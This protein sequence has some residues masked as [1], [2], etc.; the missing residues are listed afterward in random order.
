MTDNTLLCL[1][2]DGS[3]PDAKLFPLTVFVFITARVFELYK[4]KM[5]FFQHFQNRTGGGELWHISKSQ[6]LVFGLRVRAAICR[7]IKYQLIENTP[8]PDFLTVF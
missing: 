6:Y 8:N 5:F 2:F 1:F 7:G 3:K 4:E